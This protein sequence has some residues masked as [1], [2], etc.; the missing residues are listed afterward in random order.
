M[1]DPS[2]APSA[3]AVFVNLPAP[4]A[5]DAAILAA[6]GSYGGSHGSCSSGLSIGSISAP[7]TPPSPSS[8][9]GLPIFV[10]VGIARHSASIIAAQDV[11]GSAPGPVP[12][13]QKPFVST[14][15]NGLDLLVV[16]AGFVEL[17]DAAIKSSGAPPCCRATV[18]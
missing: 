5:G 1:H 10:P 12:L 7:A 9:S 17:K 3:A 4:G 13:S 11:S 8:H 16:G 14:C 2:V 15:G 18:H 6:F